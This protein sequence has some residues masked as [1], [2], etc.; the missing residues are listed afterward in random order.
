[1]RTVEHDDDHEA[2]ERAEAREKGLRKAGLVA[3]QKWEDW[4][5]SELE[6]T[7]SY[8]GAMTEAKENSAALEGE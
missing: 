8:G 2:L 4:V 3:Q 1:M 6:G 7:N 5:S